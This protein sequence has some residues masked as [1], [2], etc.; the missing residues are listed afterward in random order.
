MIVQYRE[1]CRCRRQK[2]GPTVCIA[3]SDDRYTVQYGRIRSRR[4]GP[5]LDKPASWR[6]AMAVRYENNMRMRTAR[7]PSSDRSPSLPARHVRTVLSSKP[8]SALGC[9]RPPT[10]RDSAA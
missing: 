7:T 8:S 9:G 4:P 5:D 1:G 2:R 6:T 3:A 10:T